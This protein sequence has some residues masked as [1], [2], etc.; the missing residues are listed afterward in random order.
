MS[1]DPEGAA[2]WEEEEGKWLERP[3]LCSQRCHL[4]ASCS[5]LAHT[6]TGYA[7]GNDLPGTLPI[8]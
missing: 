1:V 7:D 4:V 2:L 8:P 5:F 6:V 3:H